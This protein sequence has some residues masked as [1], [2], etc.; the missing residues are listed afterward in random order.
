MTGS[1][2]NIWLHSTKYQ[3][4]KS[5]QL[6]TGCC[7]HLVPC[8][9]WR[10]TTI[11]PVLSNNDLSKVNKCY[12]TTVN[13]IYN[14]QIQFPWN[15]WGGRPNHYIISAV[16]CN[17]NPIV[18]AS[19]STFQTSSPPYSQLLLPI[20]L[21]P[22]FSCS[23]SSISTNTVLPAHTNTSLSTNQ[24]VYTT[25]SSIYHSLTTSQIPFVSPKP[26]KILASFLS[27]PSSFIFTP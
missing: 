11:Y 3:L 1:V 9:S 12:Q 19:F 18:Y 15:G 2:T 5:K 16:R 25:P 20:I 21:L 26:P 6:W 17:K 4:H 22:P 10:T 7:Q 8:S 13:A 27:R 14:I 24:C 23:V